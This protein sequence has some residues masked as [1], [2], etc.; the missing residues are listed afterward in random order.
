MIGPDEQGSLEFRVTELMGFSSKDHAF[1][2]ADVLDSA[3]GIPQLFIHGSADSGSAAELLARNAPLPRKLLTV[4]GADHHFS[5][6]EL[7]LRSALIE[8][9]RWI[10]DSTQRT[11]TPAPASR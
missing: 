11:C 6:R 1:R 2:V 7:E 8:G 4:S 9:L 10:L 5:G 3:R